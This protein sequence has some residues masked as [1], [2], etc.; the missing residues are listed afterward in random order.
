MK[1]GNDIRAAHRVATVGFGY[2]VK[3]VYKGM[4]ISLACDGSDTWV[5]DDSDPLGPTLF[6]TGGTGIISIMKAKEWVDNYVLNS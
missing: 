1:D 5:W 2:N 4:T 3:W 6:S